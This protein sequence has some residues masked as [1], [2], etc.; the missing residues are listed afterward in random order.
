MAAGS[1]V[2]RRRSTFAGLEKVAI[3]LVTI[4]AKRV[5]HLARENQTAAAWLFHAR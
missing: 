2:K 1:S 5:I 3:E 4:D